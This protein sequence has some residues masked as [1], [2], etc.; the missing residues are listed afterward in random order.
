MVL[1]PA[2]EQKRVGASVDAVDGVRDVEDLPMESA[3]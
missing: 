2:R 3:R 1:Q